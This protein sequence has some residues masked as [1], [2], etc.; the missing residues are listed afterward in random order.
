[1]CKQ[2]VIPHAIGGSVYA[3]LG[4]HCCRPHRQPYAHLRGLLSKMK[5]LLD[6]IRGRTRSPPLSRTQQERMVSFSSLSFI[7]TAFLRSI[8]VR[9][10]FF[11]RQNEVCGDSNRAPIALNHAAEEPECEPRTTSCRPSSL[12]D[13][14]QGAVAFI[15][16][17]VRLQLCRVQD[18]HQ[19]PNRL[20]HI[21]THRS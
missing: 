14:L 2:L 6:T 4:C 19:S 16:R 15:C 7:C 1:M 18:S 5:G 3:R 10:S 12:H 11:R 8:G 20:F 21:L 9:G 17:L 13:Y